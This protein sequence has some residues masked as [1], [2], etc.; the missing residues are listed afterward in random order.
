MKDLGSLESLPW[1]LIS[2]FT[3]GLIP[4]RKPL[5]GRGIRVQPC[6][7]QARWSCLLRSVSLCTRKHW[8][9]LHNVQHLQQH[10]S[11]MQLPAVG[12]AIAFPLWRGKATW[13]CCLPCACCAY[14]AAGQNICYVKAESNPAP[15][16][17]SFK[18]SSI[19]QSR[20]QAMIP[21]CNSW[22]RAIQLSEGWLQSQVKSLWKDKAP[23][24]TQNR[25]WRGKGGAEY[26]LFYTFT[27]TV[28][29]QRQKRCAPYSHTFSSLF[30]SSLKSAESHKGE[31]R[32][33]AEVFGLQMEG[34]EKSQKV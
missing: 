34:G 8:S 13:V 25:C 2:S 15:L 31:V 30:S 29:W 9:A 22:R 7:F 16:Q 33:G 26:V 11:S 17:F 10:R 18:V 5:P 3:Q 21:K 19:W 4:V 23:F 20:A 12:Q 14:W 24:R 32:W 28:I 6:P 1:G 27:Y